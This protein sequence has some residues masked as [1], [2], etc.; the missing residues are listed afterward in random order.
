VHPNTQL[1]GDGCAATYIYQAGVTLSGSPGNIVNGYHLLM[2]TAPTGGPLQQNVVVEDIC[3]VGDNG[4][5][6][7]SAENA[8]YVFRQPQMDPLTA[9]AATYVPGGSVA[10]SSDVIVRSC[11]FLSL[12]GHVFR[13]EGG[14]QKMLFNGNRCANCG[15]GIYLDDS[16]SQIN[17]NTLDSVL[18]I[19]ATN[20]RV[21]V[22]RNIIRN[23]GSSAIRI[24]GGTGRQPYANDVTGTA[25][26]GDFGC[27]VADNVIDAPAALGIIV[28]S[29]LVGAIIARNQISRVPAGHHGISFNQVTGAAPSFCKVE[30]NVIHSVGHIGIWCGS[31]GHNNVFRRNKITINAMSGSTGTFVGMY[32]GPGAS[33]GF[34]G[35]TMR[36]MEHSTISFSSA[37]PTAACVGTKGLSAWRRRAAPSLRKKAAPS[38]SP[39]ASRPKPSRY[40]CRAST[41]SP[42]AS[43]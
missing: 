16:E 12:Y 29:P 20:Q 42:T 24:G 2:L 25:A 1:R 8:R 28:T 22:C 18:G 36:S 17:D 32:I 41:T 4:P 23:A 3:F 5:S 40:L 33:D 15:G 14:G 7:I 13:S 37:R 35:R 38:P 11:R 21:Q 30:D 27:I 31:G 10:G 34:Q 6:P 39:E 43:R 9:P 26:I 19:L